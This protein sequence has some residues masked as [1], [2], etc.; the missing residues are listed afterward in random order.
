LWAV[1]LSAE[2]ELLINLGMLYCVPLHEVM[3]VL[4]HHLRFW[5][6][7]FWDGSEH[8]GRYGDVLCGV[9]EILCDVI[10]YSEL[11]THLLRTLPFG[12]E[13]PPLD[14]V[15]DM[16]KLLHEGVELLLLLTER[17]LSC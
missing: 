13:A 12:F 3:E 9:E 14:I 4:I 6:A 17:G 16:V 5:L 11:V 7:R 1:A 10:A 15:V 8:L 2:G